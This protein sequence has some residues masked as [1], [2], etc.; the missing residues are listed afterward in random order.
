MGEEHGKKRIKM[1]VEEQPGGAQN[2]ERTPGFPT[3]SAETVPNEN[4]TSGNLET[5]VAESE[6]PSTDISTLGQTNETAPESLD[7]SLEG[8]GLDTDE[9]PE[10]KEKG[11]SFKVIFITAL[12]TAVIVGLVAGG[13]YVYLN[14][15]GKLPNSNK[16][17]TST[18]ETSPTPIAT[19]VA[20]PSASPSA[21]PIAKE[22]LKDYKVSILNGSGKIGEAGNAKILVEKAGFKVGST[23]NAASFDFTKTMVQVKASISDGVADLVVGTLGDGYK[24]ELGDAL[25]DSSSYDIVITVGSE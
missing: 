25:K 12:I 8:N 24:V 2:V 20:S 19:P 18:E 16:T 7:T 9:M 15:T 5:G 10:M 14:G 1:M 4:N 3:Q 13:I 21:S 11:T 22:D 17:A 6:T 23:G